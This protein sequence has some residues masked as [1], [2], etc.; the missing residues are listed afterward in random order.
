[1]SL[2]NASQLA[3]SVKPARDNIDEKREQILEAAVRCITRK[4]YEGV[5]LRDVS[6]EAGV[7]IGLIQHYF[8]SRDELLDVA[9]SHASAQLSENFQ[10]VGRGIPDPWERIVALIEQLCS[11][12]DVL[13]HTRLWMEFAG[14]AAKNPQLH[15]HLLSVYQSWHSYVQAAV[16]EGSAS[17]AFHPVMAIDDAAAVLMAFFDGYEFE[18][19]VDLIAANRED[20]RRRSTSLARALLQPKGPGTH[21]VTTPSE[22][23]AKLDPQGKK[24]NELPSP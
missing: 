20:L 19:A 11:L 14:A 8:D 5:R 12:P 17:G 13:A 4:G 22:G 24:L 9:I 3:V 10:A 21:R 23:Q 16:E 7:S 1:M 18:I 15:P 6:A 2:T